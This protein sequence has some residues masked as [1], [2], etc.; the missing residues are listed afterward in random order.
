M[1]D[2]WHY[3]LTPL[4]W[5]VFRHA[6][7]QMWFFPDQYGRS[8]GLCSDDPV[9]FNGLNEFEMTVDSI[10]AVVRSLTEKSRFGGRTSHQ[11]EVF[12]YAV[13]EAL[14]AW[15]A[16]CSRRIRR[17]AAGSSAEVFWTG[18]IPI[19]PQGLRTAQAGHAREIGGSVWAP[20]H[21]HGGSL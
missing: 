19:E 10:C 5:C 14:N 17:K 15:E 8:P 11:R 7:P 2:R 18:A 3:E 1:T 21:S 6:Q 4:G 16:S 12:S 9:L 20:H 13:T